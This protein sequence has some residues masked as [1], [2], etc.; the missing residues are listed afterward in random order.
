M[1]KIAIT[2]AFKRDVESLRIKEEKLKE[3]INLLKDTGTLP[4]VPYQ[5]HR[6]KGEWKDCIEAHIGFDLLIIWEELDNNIIKLLRI[7]THSKLFGR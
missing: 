2:K 6:L 5:T 7:G 1:Y 4:F 3:V